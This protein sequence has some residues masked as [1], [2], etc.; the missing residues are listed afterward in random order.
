MAW[1]KKL[2]QLNDVLSDL[3]PYKEGIIKYVKSSGLKPQF[4][5]T[6]G[7]A[8]DVW[9]NVLSEAD[10]HE[11]VNDL[12][13][14]VLDSYPDNP[15][16]KSALEEKEINYSLSPDIDEISNWHQVTDD[17]LEVLTM[18]KSTLLPVSFLAL[19]VVRSRAVA[20]VEIKIGSSKINIGTG[21]L[22]KVEGI[23]DLF[24]VTNFHVINDKAKIKNTR[25][26]FNYELDIN[27]NTTESKSFSINEAGPWYTSSEKEYDVCVCKLQ[28]SE[29][30][31]KEYGYLNL[32]E[33][34]VSK[35]D[36]VNIV[37]HPGGQMKQIS[38]YHNIV[39]NKDDRVVQ[40]LTDTLK[41]SSGSP[42]FNSDWNVVA[43]HHSGSGGKS[44]EPVLPPGVKSR[45]E[46]IY[47]NKIIQFISANY[48][49]SEG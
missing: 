2:T 47:I 45:N 29:E 46:G 40:Y 37:Q 6:D 8:L 41:G 28:A 34:D 35:N 15:F 16:L 32:K 22:C 23:D 20:K 14:R 3:V 26:I 18:N 30:D 44:N 24:F 42:V 48:T 4:I 27:G 19:G 9:S 31:L 12:V 1:S 33:I 13:K 38:L 21:F 43:L 17:T 11:K 49:K 7:N 5:N 36:F 25:I 39:T 10:K